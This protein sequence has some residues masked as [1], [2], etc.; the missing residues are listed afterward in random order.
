MWNSKTRRQEGL[1]KDVYERDMINYFGLGEDGRVGYGFEMHRTNNRCCNRT[2]YGVL[3]TC[4][5]LCPCCC[6]RGTTVA[7]Q[8]EYLRT[9][10]QPNVSK[11]DSTL[12]S[13]VAS[14][15]K[16]LIIEEIKEEV[17][18]PLLAKAAN[19]ASESSLLGLVKD[20]SDTGK[21]IFTTNKKDKDYHHING[22]PICFVA[23]NI[24]SFAG[25]GANLW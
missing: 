19:N 23:P 20:Q 21:I 16:D 11:N 3:G 13:Q 18:E 25:G 24:S 7:Q 10:K 12:K 14:S 1:G 5:F 9:L 4:Y 17:K 2:V 6:Q 15:N 8:I 22:N